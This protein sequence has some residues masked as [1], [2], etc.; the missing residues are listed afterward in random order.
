MHH[1]W[2]VSGVMI[3]LE[4]NTTTFPGN[5]SSVYDMKLQADGYGKA[6]FEKLYPGNYYIYVSGFDDV[7]GSHVIGEMPV[8]LSNPANN[9]MSVTVPVSE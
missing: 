1:T 6:T 7:W 8:S 2:D 9:H 3:Y 5:D 4:R